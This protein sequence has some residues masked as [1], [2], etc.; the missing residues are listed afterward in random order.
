VA[1]SGRLLPH[2]LRLAIRRLF[3]GGVDFHS[4]DVE[5]RDGS[6]TF[7]GESLA[8][9]FHQDSAHGFRGSTEEVRAIF[10]AR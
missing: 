5:R 9:A 1:V 8:R 2:H 3:T 10:K 6:A 4:L 7:D